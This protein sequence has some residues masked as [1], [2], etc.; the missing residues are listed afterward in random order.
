MITKRAAWLIRSG[1][2]AARHR[3]FPYTKGGQNTLNPTHVPL[4]MKAWHRTNA[5]MPHPRCVSFC[6]DK[7]VYVADTGYIL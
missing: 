1:I 2:V 4:Y 3:E 5:K 6:A 7:G